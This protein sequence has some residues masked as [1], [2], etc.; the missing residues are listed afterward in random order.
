MLIFKIKFSF[1]FFD[2]FV[3][4]I[5]LFVVIHCVGVISGVLIVNICGVV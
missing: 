2:F 1:S 5:P 4:L 3:F